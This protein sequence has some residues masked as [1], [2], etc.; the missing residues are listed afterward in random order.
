MPITIELPPEAERRLTELAAQTGRDVDFYLREIVQ[1]VL[2]DVEDHYLA[3]KVMERVRKGEEPLY[4]SAE[5][6]EYLGI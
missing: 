2:E 6:R 1:S 3:E 4:S 5:V